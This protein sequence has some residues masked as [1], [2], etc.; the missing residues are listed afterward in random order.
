MSENKFDVRAMMNEVAELNLAGMS[1]FL[2]ERLQ[3]YEHLPIAEAVEKTLTVNDFHL[4]NY[5]WKKN[6]VV[7]KDDN[8]EVIKFTGVVMLVEVEDKSYTITTRSRNIANKFIAL[9]KTIKS[10]QDKA[11]ES[12]NN[13]VSKDDLDLIRRLWIGRVKPFI[14]EGKKDGNYI[15]Y[16]VK[17]IV[18]E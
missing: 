18:E 17:G 8:G 15:S 14:I 11:R 1:D 2:P 6:D 13:E 5:A 9:D 4:Y 12:S 16:F 3:G 10:S 7:Q